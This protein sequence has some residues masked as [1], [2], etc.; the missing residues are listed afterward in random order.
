MVAQ[1]EQLRELEAFVASAIANTH[2]D[3]TTF[4]QRRF[5]LR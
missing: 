1:E 3:T 2:Y 5:V 4:I